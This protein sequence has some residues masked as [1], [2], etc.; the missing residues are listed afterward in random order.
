PA[1]AGSGATARATS[2]PPAAPGPAASLA[3][4][5][6]VVAAGDIACDP[7]VSSGAPARCDQAATAAQILALRPDAVLSLGDNQYERNTAAAY[8]SVFDVSWGQF[9]SLI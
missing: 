8:A 5:A 7:S 2:E 6:A 1:V 3:A 9:K 4:D